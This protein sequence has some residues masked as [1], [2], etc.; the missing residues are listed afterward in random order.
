M[1]LSALLS[2]SLLFA[3]LLANDL[4]A[5]R[6]AWEKGDLEDASRLVDEHLAADQSDLDAHLLRAEIQLALDDPDSVLD[7]LDPFDA[8]GEARVKV[9]LG[10]AFEDIGLRLQDQGAGNE[11]VGYYLELALAYY[12]EAADLDGAGSIDG[13]TRAGYLSLYTFGNWRGAR[14]RADAN[15]ERA[16]EDPELLHLRGCARVFEYV[17]LK[18]A[19]EQAPAQAAWD[20]AVEDLLA[21]DRLHGGTRGD[22]HWQL[23]FLYEDAGKAEEAVD[24]AVTHMQRTPDM[25]IGRVYAL[26]KRY[27]AE[28]RFA[29]SEKALLAMVERDAEELSNWIA[30]EPDP[31][32][33]AV[34][35]G[36]SIGPA[37][38][39]GRLEAAREM[40]RPLLEVNPANADIWNNFGLLCRDTGVATER[41]G[42]IDAAEELYVSS[43]VAYEKSLSHDSENPQIMNDTALVMQYHVKTN[44]AR[45]KDLYRRA[46]VNAEKLI[47]GGD[48]RAEI[49]TALRDARNNL[50]L[51]GG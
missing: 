28:K 47:A 49:R 48:E 51:L 42:D 17:E 25:D 27:A 32:E 3:P 9:L 41:R 38:Q 4:S 10:R 23:A 8:L 24:A 16:A 7:S 13:A 37:V 19:E 46:I 50:A 29:A 43:Y 15:L 26:A 45:A 33:T 11:D 21:S 5:A 22:A 36:W 39:Q 20:A 12:E 40:L 34:Q 2:S 35:L 44:M 18:P 1:I 30:S 31:T 14:A 6:S